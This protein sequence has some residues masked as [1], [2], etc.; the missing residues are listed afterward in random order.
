MRCHAIPMGLFIK[1]YLRR[2][3]R[4]QVP[5]YDMCRLV[6]QMPLNEYFYIA[7]FVKLLKCVILKG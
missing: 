5:K 3:V 6:N 7:G 1:V 4:F 2:Q